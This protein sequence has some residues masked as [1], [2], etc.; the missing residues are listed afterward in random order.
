MRPAAFKPHPFEPNTY[1]AQHPVTIRAMKK[2]IFAAGSELFEDLEDIV[3]CSS[4]FQ[5]LDRQ[6]WWFCPYCESSLPKESDS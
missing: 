5:E 1:L 6:F 2:D 3:S 4:C